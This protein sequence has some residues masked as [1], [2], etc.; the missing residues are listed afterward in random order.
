MNKDR[1]TLLPCANVAGMHKLKMFV[2]GKFKKPRAFK[3]LVHFPVH[4]DASENAWMIAT[5]F[6]WWFFHCFV[7]EV[8]EYLREQGLSEDSK[9][10]L[11]M[12]NCR[13]H[14]PAHELVCGNI[15]S[16]KFH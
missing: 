3:N 16:L 4:Y 11:I 13:A 2:V 7:P 14:P 9:V 6:K 10:I 12:D 1:V 15:F 5:L 8:K